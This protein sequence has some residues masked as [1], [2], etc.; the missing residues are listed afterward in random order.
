[1]EQITVRN[2]LIKFKETIGTSNQFVAN[3]IK[4][5]RSTISK[6]TTGKDLPIPLLIRLDKFITNTIYKLNRL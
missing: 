3:Q 1:M 2:R 4:C 5:D 6:F